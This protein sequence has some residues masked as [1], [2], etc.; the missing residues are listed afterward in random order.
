MRLNKCIKRKEK[1]LIPS[2]PSNNTHTKQKFVDCLV[3]GPR[4]PL[5]V[6]FAFAVVT[7]A[8]RSLVREIRLVAVEN[9]GASE[10]QRDAQVGYGHP[11]RHDEHQRLSGRALQCPSK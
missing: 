3:L 7:H 9:S 6:G 10:I 5:G 4:A 1:E 8:R 11:S 2:A